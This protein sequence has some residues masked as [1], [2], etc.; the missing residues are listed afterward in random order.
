MQINGVTASSSFGPAESPGA[1]KE[2]GKESFLQ[3]LVTQMRYQDPLSPMDNQAFLAQL[4]QFS[5]LEQMQNL[6]QKYDATVALT[7]SLSN[8]AATA[9]IGRQVRASGSSVELGESGP[10]GLGYF[11]AQEAETVTLTIAD[12]EGRPVRT[13]VSSEGAA[14]A[15]RLSWDGND[16]EGLRLPPGTYTIRVAAVDGSGAEVAAS[17]L[18]EGV[19]DGV[20]FRN[21]SAFLMVGGREISLSQLLE[22]SMDGS[23]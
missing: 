4:A 15:H 10:A 7:Q 9:M 22:V 18:I 2:L 20:T 11:L 17:S 16:A 23:R 1:G 12:G 3:L 13:L 14:G 5:S 21:G 19:V 6:N 8:S